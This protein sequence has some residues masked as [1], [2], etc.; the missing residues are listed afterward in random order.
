M[1][2]V[3]HAAHLRREMARRGWAATDL[4]RAARLSQATISTALAG[5]PIAA[6]SLALIAKA[7]HKTPIID[8]IDSLIMGNEADI[9]L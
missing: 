5:K 2:L 6:Q 9:A 4:A 7:L 3:V 1:S 8:N